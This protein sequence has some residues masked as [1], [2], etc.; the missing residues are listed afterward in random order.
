MH[1][2]KGCATDV[3]LAVAPLR[4][5][6]APSARAATEKQMVSGGGDH[7]AAFAQRLSAYC[8]RTQS[9]ICPSKMCRG[10]I[11]QLYCSYLIHEVG[12][13]KVSF[14][15]PLLH[16]RPSWILVKR[17]KTC[18]LFDQKRKTPR[19]PFQFRQTSHVCVDNESANHNQEPNGLFCQSEEPGQ[20]SATP[21]TPDPVPGSLR[22]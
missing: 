14:S 8:P 22:L 15:P 13:L 19:S 11:F 16:F 10:H 18:L 20:A 9:S 12:G 3:P 4:P 17:L 1:L 7:G 6:R 2:G 21:G 5:T